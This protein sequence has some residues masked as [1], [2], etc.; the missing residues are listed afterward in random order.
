[1]LRNLEHQ[2]VIDANSAVDD[3]VGILTQSLDEFFPRRMRF[4]LSSKGTCVIGLT[5]LSTSNDEQ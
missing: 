2:G 3:G 4:E 1:M 5:V